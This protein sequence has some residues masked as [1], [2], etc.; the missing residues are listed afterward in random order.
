MVE[1]K[2]RDEIFSADG[3]KII[4]TMENHLKILGQDVEGVS[5]CEIV[6]FSDA[7]KVQE[8]LLYLNPEKIMAVF[9]KAQEG[10]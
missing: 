3:K 4:K 10:K 1:S 6:T 2:T 9:A 5:E 7:G 8:Y